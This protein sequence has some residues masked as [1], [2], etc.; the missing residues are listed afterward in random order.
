M[1]K[2]SRVFGLADGSLDGLTN[3]INQKVQEEN[4]DPKVLVT[5]ASVSYSM[6]IHKRNP[7]FSALVVFHYQDVK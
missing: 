5:I 2:A 6:V 3:K 7:V 1:I 4:F